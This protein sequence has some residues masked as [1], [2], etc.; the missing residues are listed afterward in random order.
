MASGGS[1]GAG[2]GGSGCFNG[3]G[4]GGG[5]SLTGSMTQYGDGYA[6]GFS[7]PGFGGGAG[8]YRAWNRSLAI[9]NDGTTSTG[10]G[11]DGGKYGGGGGGDSTSNNGGNGS[12]GG[13]GA[14]RIIWGTGRAFPSTNAY[15]FSFAEAR[16]NPTQA[17]TVSSTIHPYD[18][19]TG[20]VS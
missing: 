2:G 18:T 16:D 20:G 14:V 5:T 13:S 19:Y 17:A 3:A 8:S 7:N 6:Q 9:G 11:G 15:K 12:Q 4:G 1:G 10:R